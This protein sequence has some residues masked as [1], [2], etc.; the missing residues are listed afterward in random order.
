[1]KVDASSLPGAVGKAAR[2]FVKRFGPQTEIRH[3]QEWTGNN[4]QGYRGIRGTRGTRRDAYLN[5]Y[6]PRPTAASGG[7]R[8]QRVRHLKLLGETLTPRRHR[9]E[10][11]PPRRRV[12]HTRQRQK[13]HVQRHV[14]LGGGAG[15]VRLP[16]G[17]DAGAALRAHRRPRNGLHAARDARFPATGCD[18]C[19]RRVGAGSRGVEPWPAGAVGGTPA[20]G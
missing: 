4:N 11:G 17:A 3:E 19:R 9:L 2:D 20:E 6:Q 13:P 15:H 5:L 10:A 1:M 16:P 12:R 7:R 18:G 8:S 14:W